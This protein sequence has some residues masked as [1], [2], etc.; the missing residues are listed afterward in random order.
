MRLAAI[1][2]RPVPADVVGILDDEG[3]EADLAFA[4]ADEDHDDDDARSAPRSG[5]DADG[6]LDPIE[7]DE[8][9]TFPEDAP[10]PEGD[11]L[12]GPEELE[13]DAE[14][15]E[16]EGDD[17]DRDER[18]AALPDDAEGPLLEDEADLGLTDHDEPAA[19]H[20]EAD[21]EGAS[22]DD[23]SFDLVELPPL[24]AD[25]DDGALF[26]EALDD[27]EL[28]PEPGIAPS[29]PRATPPAVQDRSPAT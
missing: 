18:L 19:T 21:D 14:L 8:L 16:D 3:F 2:L 20:L 10:R 26:D 7:D 4:A 29:P 15:G 27:L 23:A 12:L 22:V 17:D 11:D 9:L 28:E 5:D 13:D 6:P 24:G 25:L 1:A